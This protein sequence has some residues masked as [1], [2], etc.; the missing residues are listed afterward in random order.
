MDRNN[1]NRKQKT[2]AGSR[3]I[4]KGNHKVGSFLPGLI[5]KPKKNN[6]YWNEIPKTDAKTAIY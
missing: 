5:Q 2:N 3:K 6:Q 1:N 4:H